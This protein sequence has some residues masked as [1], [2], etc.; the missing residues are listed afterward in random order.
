MID[1]E[2]NPVHESEK[3]LRGPL[4]ERLEARIA[5]AGALT[6]E[7]FVEAALYDESLGYYRAGKQERQDYYTSSEIHGLFGR[8]I[9]RYIEG[10]CGL[11]NV[12]AVNVLELGG[13]SGRLAAE[14]VGALSQVSLDRYLILENGEEKKREKIEW[15]NTFEH[16][17]PF[18]GFTVVVA[19]EFFDALPFHKII[20]D[21]G[22]LKEVYVGYDRGFF[23]QAGPLSEDAAL[24]LDRFPIPLSEKQALEVTPRLAPVIANL[25]RTIRGAACLLVFDYG[26]HNSEINGGRFFGGTAVGYRGWRMQQNIFVNPGEMDITHHVNFDHLT[27]LL[28]ENGWRKGGEIEQYR[29]LCNIGI[30]EAFG[31]L[32][33]EERMSAK[34][35]INP[36]GL[37]SMISALGFSKGLAFPLPGFHHRVMR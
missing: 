18:T 33:Q 9:G 24:F 30:L 10:L 5:Q 14:I 22:N 17:D 4:E 31:E 34:W 23:E 27:A 12:S 25:S 8:L 36:E 37:G 19:N 20:C 26:Y 3:R 32:P 16:I 15:V 28:A 29:F 1:R 35:L 11:L 2:Q 6:Y 21:S 7:G 13:A